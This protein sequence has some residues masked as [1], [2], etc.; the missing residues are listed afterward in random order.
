M[1]SLHGSSQGADSGVREWQR[2]LSDM[3]FQRRGMSSADM[4]TLPVSRAESCALRSEIISLNSRWLDLEA[5]SRPFGFA[6]A[7]VTY[8]VVFLPSCC[9]SVP[10]K[11]RIAAFAFD[12]VLK[13]TKPYP[14]DRE[15]LVGSVDILA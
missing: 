9:I 6:A 14:S 5:S 7:K 8:I 15:L 2:T 1:E 3:I 12:T 4:T 11:A 10:L 13:P